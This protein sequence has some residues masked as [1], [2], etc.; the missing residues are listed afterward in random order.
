MDEEIAK[1]L[2]DHFVCIKVDRE[3]RPD[4]DAIYMQSL[5]IVNPRTSGGWPLSMF[6]TPDAKPFFGGTYF[7]ARDGDRGA[8]F[9]FFVHCKA[10]ASDVA[11]EW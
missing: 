5:R 6:L 10:S 2:N 3:E 8:R 1:F 11:E 7:P 4:V 9:G